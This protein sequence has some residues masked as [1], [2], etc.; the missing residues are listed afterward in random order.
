MIDGLFTPLVGSSYPIAIFDVAQIANVPEQEPLCLSNQ[1]CLALKAIRAIK[2]GKKLEVIQD[3]PSFCKLQHCTS[4]EAVLN[5]VQRP[6]NSKRCYRFP[7]FISQL[8]FYCLQLPH[9]PGPSKKLVGDCAF[10]IQRRLG[11]RFFSDILAHHT[12]P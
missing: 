6:L 10:V 2:A 5:R 4:V 9:T 1:I 11:P 7:H 12:M 3:Q 8:P